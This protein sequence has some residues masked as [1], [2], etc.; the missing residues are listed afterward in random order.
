MTPKV[1]DALEALLEHSAVE[2]GFER[3]L[4]G[5]EVGKKAKLNDSASLYEH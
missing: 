4:N 3:A 1:S 5:Q 2:S